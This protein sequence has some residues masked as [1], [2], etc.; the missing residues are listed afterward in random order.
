ML[1]V[2]YCEVAREVVGENA[3]SQSHARSVTMD[4][5]R[6]ELPSECS[7]R[8][9]SSGVSS[10]DSVSKEKARVKVIAGILPRWGFAVQ[11]SKLIYLMYTM[12]YNVEA[13]NQQNRR[14]DRSDEYA[15]SQLK[16]K[17][18]EILLRIFLLHLP[19]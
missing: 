1:C 10:S 13:I 14:V 9:L 8:L 3:L 2:V 16:N 11:E 19:R 6:S 12:K 18:M 7:D 15:A 5:I 4:W 17:T